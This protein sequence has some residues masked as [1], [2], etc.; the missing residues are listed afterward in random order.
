M[1]VLYLLPVAIREVVC[2]DFWSSLHVFS[3]Y[4]RVGRP[5]LPDVIPGSLDIS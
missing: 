2:S 1:G 4:I 5:P 3:F